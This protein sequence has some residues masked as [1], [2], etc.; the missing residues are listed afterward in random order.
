MRNVMPM[1]KL[2][3]ASTPITI[4]NPLGVSERCGQ[5][6]ASKRTGS[7]VGL[8]YCNN[9]DYRGKMPARKKQNRAKK[10]AGKK[11]QP[12]ASK[13]WTAAE[14]EE[15]FTRLARANPEPKG[16]LQ[17]ADPFTLLVAVV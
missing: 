16:E 11:P 4:A 3:P 1:T 8:A 10:P 2:M 13:P 14:I 6:C 7:R 15:A 9:A 17:H 5:R 12:R